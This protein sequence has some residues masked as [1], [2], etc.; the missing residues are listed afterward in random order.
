MLCC[1]IAVLFFQQPDIVVQGLGAP[2]GIEAEYKRDVSD[3]ERRSFERAAGLR[4]SEGKVTGHFFHYR[5]AGGQEALLVRVLRASPLVESVVESAESRTEP[6]ATGGVDTTLTFVDPCLRGCM[7]ASRAQILGPLGETHLVRE[8]LLNFFHS[9]YLKKNGQLR[10]LGKDTNLL[11]FQVDHLR[12]EVIRDSKFWEQIEI[13]TVFFPVRKA[14]GRRSARPSR[15]ETV[16]G[17]VE[18]HIFLDGKYAAGLGDNPPGESGFSSM[19]PEFYRQE[20]DYVAAIAAS[21][22]DLAVEKGISDRNPNRF[23]KHR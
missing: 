9:M 21:V 6:V 11:H 4:S 7:T 12:G 1:L 23:Y 5:V 8:M 2:G 18:L 22:N 14:S 19:E 20:N 15:E 3:E 10:V 13:Y 17:V 16:P